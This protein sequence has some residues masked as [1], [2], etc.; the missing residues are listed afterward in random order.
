F[1]NV[2]FLMTEPN[3]GV[4]RGWI[5][6]YNGSDGDLYE[7]TSVLSRFFVPSRCSPGPAILARLRAIRS[8]ADEA[9]V[10]GLE[11]TEQKHGARIDRIQQ[12]GDGTRLSF[13]T[14]TLSQTFVASSQP[15]TP[16]WHVSVNGR[17]AHIY[18]VNDAFIGFVVPSGH[19]DVLVYYHP[20]SFLVGLII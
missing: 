1:L 17:A 2:R 5:R 15:L 9:I 4:G 14:E 6:R 18:R 11:P 10:E 12:N 19:S 20:R 13:T 16:G 3:L 8:F 7:S